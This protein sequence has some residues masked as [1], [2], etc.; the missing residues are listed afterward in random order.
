MV[1]MLLDTAPAEVNTGERDFVNLML[2]LT[3]KQKAAM[4][5]LL[6]SFTGYKGQTEDA[7]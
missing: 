6:D 2:S 4:L 1:A 5:A 3:E 7:G